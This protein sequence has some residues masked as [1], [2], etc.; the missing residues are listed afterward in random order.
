MLIHELILLGIL[1]GAAALCLLRLAIGPSLPD[2]VVALDV[3]A[4]IG[5]A[6]S[7]LYAVAVDQP[8]YLDVAVIFALVNFVGTVAFARYLE[9]R[10]QS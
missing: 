9:K 8:V 1:A 10:V 6:I 5:V 2:R 7:A 3:L 4:I